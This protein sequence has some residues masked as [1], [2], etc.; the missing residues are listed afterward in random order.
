TDEI[1]V[2]D[3]L[4]PEFDTPEA[5]VDEIVVPDELPPEFQNEP[6]QPTSDP[7]GDFIQNLPQ[8]QV[9]APMAPKQAPMAPQ[10]PQEDPLMARIRRE[11]YSNPEYV[12]NAVMTGDPKKREFILQNLGS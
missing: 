8:R 9:E 11:G 10:P 12:Y 7:L 4:P 3:E 6:E 1:V 2:P 5:A